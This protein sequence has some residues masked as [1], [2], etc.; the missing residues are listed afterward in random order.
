MVKTTHI[1]IKS[2]RISDSN[3]DKMLKISV[4]ITT[5][6]RRHLLQKAIRSVLGQS[7]SPHEI[8]VIDDGSEDGTDRLVREQF[9]QIIYHRQANRGISAA[10]NNGIKMSTG[11]WIAFLDADDEWLPDKLYL[12]ATALEQNPGHNICHTDEQW[13]RHGRRVNQMKKHRKYGGNIFEKCLPLC[14]ISPSSVIIKQSLFDR[15]GLFNTALPV[16]E[17][18]EMWLRICA[19]EPV[20]Y[21]DQPLIIKYGGHADQL[22]RRY[23]GMDRFR[24]MALE[25]ILRQEDL[26]FNQRLAVLQTLIKKT[27]IVRNGAEKR[28]NT[29]LLSE[30]NEKL[31]RYNNVLNMLP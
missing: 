30:Y 23:W 19:K 28:G 5:F 21:I 13:I 25:N 18:Y 11:D 29:K 24:I 7:Y 27:I 3:L 22:S 4:I 17:D 20:L 2:A 16:C 9:P 1:N 26:D 8:I 12:Q 6:N 15:T 10:R 31:T 14:I